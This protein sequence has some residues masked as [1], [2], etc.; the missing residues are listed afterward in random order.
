MCIGEAPEKTTLVRK[1]DAEELQVAIQNR[2]RPMVI[3]FYATWCGP[4]VLMATELEKV[5]ADLGDSVEILK[6][7]TDEN[8]QLSSQL[9][10]QGLP[11]IMFIGT[12]PQKPALRVEGLVPADTV[13]EIIAND[14]Q[15]PESMDSA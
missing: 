15:A 12:D 13:K 10:I 7:D 3:D 11:T 5:A 14:L 2:D 9:R 8:P 4:C 1:V 6:I